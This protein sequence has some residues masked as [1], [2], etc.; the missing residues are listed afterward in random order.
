M[1]FPC[2]VIKKSQREQKNRK[3]CGRRRGGP[4]DSPASSL[5]FLS[6]IDRPRLCAHFTNFSFAIPAAVEA[7][8][9]FFLT[10]AESVNDPPPH[11]N[12]SSFLNN[13]TPPFNPRS[14][15]YHPPLYGRAHC[16]A[17]SFYA[18]SCSL[19]L[20]TEKKWPDKDRKSYANT[21]HLHTRARRWASQSVRKLQSHPV[22]SNHYN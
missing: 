9:Y 22:C 3:L 18:Y 5:L 16:Y 8:L 17:H 20:F 11:L 13:Q 6:L 1:L 7:R 15:L 4:A 21:V 2:F 14:P 10:A 12:Y 19:A